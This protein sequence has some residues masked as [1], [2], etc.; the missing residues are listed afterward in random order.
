MF[1]SGA[2]M[3]DDVHLAANTESNRVVMG[4]GEDG[5]TDLGAGNIVHNLDPSTPGTLAPFTVPNGDYPTT[6]QKLVSQGAGADAFLIQPAVT[7]SDAS[8]LLNIN[9][10]VADGAAS[11]YSLLQRGGQTY[12]G[13]HAGNV[14]YNDETGAARVSWSNNGRTWTVNGTGN[15]IT[16]DTGGAHNIDLKGFRLRLQVSGARKIGLGTGQPTDGSLTAG[17]AII[18]FDDTNGNA[19]ISARGKTADGTVVQGDLGALT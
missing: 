6:F 19:K 12:A 10:S 11:V 1:D 18:Y 16:V 5:F 15:A 9:K 8:A 4:F 17:E 13:T 14:V 7:T 2:S 3:T